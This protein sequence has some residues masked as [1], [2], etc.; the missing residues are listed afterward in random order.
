MLEAAQVLAT[1]AVAAAIVF[2]ATKGPNMADFAR[3]TAAVDSVAASILSVAEA[4]RNPASDNV[5]QEA[6]DALATRLEEAA[7]TLQGLAAEEQAEDQGPTPTPT[8]TPT[9]PTE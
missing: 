9:E 8:P 4:I 1:L 5:D 6:A 2:L 3:L 7:A